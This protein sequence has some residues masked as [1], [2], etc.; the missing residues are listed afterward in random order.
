MAAS[1]PGE[2]ADDL[3]G[4]NHEQGGEAEHHG[5][6]KADQHADEFPEVRFAVA[7]FG[8]AEDGNQRAV[9]VAADEQ[10]IEGFGH[11]DGVVERGQQR[12]R[13]K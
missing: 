11:N 8:F 6:D 10:V 9:D 12:R 13:T 2:N 7:G 5:G 3:G 1:P 4:E